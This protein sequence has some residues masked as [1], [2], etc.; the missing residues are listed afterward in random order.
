VHL[1][2]SRTGIAVLLAL[3]TA[4]L[5]AGGVASLAGASDTAHRIWIAATLAVLGPSVLD[6][7]ARL[8]QR[9]AGV[10][11]IA[12]LAMAG[13]LMY[14]EYLAAVIVAVMLTLGSALE[15]YAAGRARRDLTALIER[16]PRGAHRVADGYIEAIPVAEV[17]PG[18]IL[19]VREADLVPVDGTV[20]SSGAHLDE[21]MLTGE[22]R[23]VHR[24]TGD[25]VFSGTVNAG[26][27]FRMI[28]QA[29]ASDSAY[30]GIARLVAEAQ[31]SH[32]PLT[33]LADRY[34]LLFIPVTLALAGVAWAWSDDPVRAV[35]VLV[36][37]TPC[38]L[39]LGA[40][41]AIVAGLSRSARQGAI[42]KG[43][44]ALEALARAEVV[45]LD[46]TGTLTA[47]HPEVQGI[48]LAGGAGDE[49]EVLRLAASLDQTSSHVLAAAL[50]RAA[51]SRGLQLTIPDEVQEHLGAGLTGRVAQQAVTVGLPEWVFE[52]VS[53]A[54]AAPLRR[55]LEHH[56][57]SA[58][59]VAVDG[60][61]AG[62]ILLDDPLR[63]DTPRTVRALR[64]QGIRHVVMVTGDHATVAGAIGAALGIDTVLA[65]QRPDDKVAA[66]RDWR[67]R[68]ITVMVGD[69]I[70]D[71]P[72]LAAADVGVAMG[73]RG[74]TAASDSADIVLMRD[75]L[76]TL[77][78]ARQIATR[79]R[80]IALESVL[81]GMGLSM[82]AMVI[83]ALG[84]LPPVAGAVLQEGID[85]IAIGIALRALLPARDERRAPTIPEPLATR[86][87]AE[88][89]E[90][91][92]QLDRFRRAARD[93]A[94]ANGDPSRADLSATLDFYRTV[95]LPHESVDEREVY[96][97]LR[98]A[99]VD[100]AVLDAMSRSHA[101][102][103]HLGQQLEHQVSMLPDGPLALADLQEL[104][105]ILY[106]L[107]AVLRLH[108]AQEEELYATLHD[109]YLDLGREEDPA[110]S[111]GEREASGE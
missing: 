64:Q 67:A 13:A 19:L 41:I 59:A 9:E 42:V 2:H 99:Q 92:P 58:I 46:K 5:V 106:A 73:A 75:R 49:N 45:L 3:A 98:D 104:Q 28:A 48:A 57:G 6:A 8:R 90:L 91:M 15:A 89:R 23:L 60:A 68:G 70:N 103:F 97:A 111:V 17:R 12:I 31:A 80:R 16:A 14:G 55:R 50:V 77:V 82:G 56:T 29:T 25:Q 34:A 1:L 40:P 96:P 47:G 33:R 95:I 7:V 18:D 26:A 72:A 21:S 54:N 39:L 86:L 22:S 100:D 37:A 32:A 76:D 105:R 84:Y 71:A 78:A 109:E 62:V 20:E 38:P 44:A 93:L 43:G 35:A 63:A 36:V 51:R 65:E 102:I 11:L 66:V 110:V 94:A 107:D 74:A 88:H 87:R 81:V 61:L 24:G 83:A 79:S 108:F 30:A 69:G 52:H 4:G 101:E 53:E 27:Q 85:I 10:D